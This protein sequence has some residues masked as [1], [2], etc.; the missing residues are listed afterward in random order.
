[1]ILPALALPG[2]DWIDGREADEPSALNK[3]G[4]VKISWSWW[5]ALQPPQS[6]PP[7]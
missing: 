1:M 7:E 2:D 6:P 5:L 4:G 3:Y